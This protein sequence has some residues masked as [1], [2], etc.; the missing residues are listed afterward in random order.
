[1][2]ALEELNNEECQYVIFKL[3]TEEFGLEI[4]HVLEIVPHLPITQMPGTT[5]SAIIGVINLRGQVI[6]II[7][8][9]RQFQLHTAM[10]IDRNT[11]IMVVEN[12]K[13]KL[14]ILVDGM[15]EVL[16]ISESAIVE[17]P[18][19]IKNNLPSHQNLG[20]SLEGLSQVVK[21]IGKLDDRLIILLDPITLALFL[22]AQGEDNG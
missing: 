1:M 4:N 9:A 2:N 15:P 16:K 17:V 11:R 8:L 13:N 21:C 5:L 10:A 20:Q 19:M 6:P 14:G 12:K 22:E 18:E 3:G 7:D